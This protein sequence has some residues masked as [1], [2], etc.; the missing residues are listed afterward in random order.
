M[1]KIIDT[2]PEI[3]SLRPSPDPVDTRPATPAVTP[4]EINLLGQK[5]LFK[6]SDSDPELIQDVVRLVSLKIS[7]AETRVRGAAPYQ[8]ALL[9]LL[10]LAEDYMKAKKRTLEFK[11]EIGLKS[12]QLQNLLENELK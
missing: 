11:K 12:N 10:D 1:E 6:S 5:I 3:S 2:S 9:A 7:E 4:I 8:T